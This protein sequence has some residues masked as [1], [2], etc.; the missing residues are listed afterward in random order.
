[1]GSE[2][3]ERIVLPP[4]RS[5]L[6]G[7]ARLYGK[8]QGNR[9]GHFVATRFTHFAFI[10]LF[11]LKSYLVLESHGNKRVG[12]EIPK[13]S[14]S[15][16]IAYFRAACILIALSAF[17]FWA[18]Y[19]EKVPF[20]Y[21]SFSAQVAIYTWFTLAA[22]GSLG[23]LYSYLSSRIASATPATEKWINTLLEDMNT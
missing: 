12:I 9:R 20:S 11:P 10:P 7:G 1:M 17:M 16:F 8:I 3:P 4:D 21:L 5:I 22:L 23:L 13:N 18:D 2:T 14:L 15:V 19:L 6:Y